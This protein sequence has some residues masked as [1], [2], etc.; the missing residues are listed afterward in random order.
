MTRAM[1][2]AESVPHD[3][4]A[5]IAR[6]A[7]GN[8]FFVEEVVKSLVELG[9]IRRAGDQYVLTRPPDQIL[10]P[11]TIQDVIMARIDR[12][13]EEPKRTLQ[14]ASVIGREF[15]G[16]LLERIADV[17]SRTEGWLQELKAIELI[18]E[19]TLFPELA[20]MF[21]HALT[22]EVAYGSLLVHR[23]KE[24]HRLVGLAIEELYA[25]R[26]AEHYEVLAHH[27]TRAEEWS[28]ALD[29]LVR[30]AEKASRA[31][32]FREAL[33]FYGQALEAAHHLGEEVPAPRLVAIHR[34][35]SQLH[36]AVADWEESRRE[37]ER[38]LDLA[39]RLGD[40]A[41]EGWALAQ[42]GWATFWAAEDFADAVAYANQAIATGEQGHA[43]S[44]VGF[45]LEVLG[46]ISAVTGRLE[47]AERQF[48]RSLAIARPTGE[49]ARQSVVRY[50]QANMRNWQGA[51]RESHDLATDGARIAREHGLVIPLIRNQWTQAVALAGVGDYDRACALLEEGLA[52]SEKIGD[53]AYIPRY[54]NTLGWLRLECHD[55]DRSLEVSRLGV[56]RA[57]RR[58][59]A[60]GVEQTV[61]TEINR[62][63]AFLARGDVDSAREL[64]AEAHDL[65]K[66]DAVYDWMRWRSAIHCFVSEGELWLACGDPARAETFADR[67]LESATQTGS[68]KYM[69][70]AWR[71]KGD[72]ARLRRDWDSAE[73]ALRE[74]LALAEPLGNPRELWQTHAAVGRLREARK[75]LDA[76]R[77]AYQSARGVVDGVV[78][79]LQHAELRAG[80]QQDPLIRE[81]YE[82]SR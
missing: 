23:R 39:R 8:P 27:F 15:T 70:R 67:S 50:F 45:G 72:A 3:V 63:D 49:V 25:D 9:V 16:R 68:R 44:A 46:S 30:A 65:V 43:A 29:Y 76:A 48:A 66:D 62:A 69:V 5:L 73:R 57:R 33:A 36:W 7:E 40:R 82:R 13:A 14:L 12:L 79:R 28:K 71:L 1:L 41:M 59:H 64:L 54:L 55:L 18:Y 81:I 17:R 38:V 2:A 21:K 26:L 24:L 75:D 20:Y 31:S 19:K 60:T 34:A 6:K 22:H 77:R 74:A 80:L 42:M 51:Y 56:E 35:K 47:Q 32:A 4:Q 53:E 37:A 11:D 78:A 58:R 61:F 52:L 10:V